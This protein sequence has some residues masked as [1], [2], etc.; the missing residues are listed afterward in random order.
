MVCIVSSDI[1][2]D[3]PTHCQFLLR[4]KREHLSLSTVGE[5]IIICWTERKETKT[6]RAKY[7]DRE[8]TDQDTKRKL[9]K[10]LVLF[11]QHPILTLHQYH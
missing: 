3:Y 11:L 1:S 2:V 5:L 6:R 8:R 9:K 7:L 10:T 4:G